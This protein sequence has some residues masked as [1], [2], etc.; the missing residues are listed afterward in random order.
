MGL[1][2]RVE[3]ILVHPNYHLFIEL[4]YL[5]INGLQTSKLWQPIWDK[6]NGCILVPTW[7]ATRVER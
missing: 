3:H 2:F 6:D 5:D 4:M 1:D 7:D